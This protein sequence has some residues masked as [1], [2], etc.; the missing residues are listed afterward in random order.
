[1]EQQK[2]FIKNI[3]IK[4]FKCFKDFKAEGFGRVNL[5]GGKNNVGKTAFMEAIYLYNSYLIE[6]VYKKLLVLKTYR[7]TKKMLISN[8][9]DE[10]NL[11]AL[12]LENLDINIGIRK[13]EK[14]N[15]YEDSYILI[16]IAQDGNIIEGYRVS[17][18]LEIIKNN[19]LIE[20]QI[21]NENILVLYTGFRDDFEDIEFENFKRS[22]VDLSDLINKLNLEFDNTKYMTAKEFI[23]SSLDDN[24]LLEDIIG[25]LKLNGNYDKFNKYIDNLFDISNVDFIKKEPMVKWNNGYKK[26]SDFGDGLKS[27]I[28]IIGS[29]LTLKDEYFYIDEIENGIHYTNL[30]KLWEIILTISKEQNVQVFATTHSKE[31]IESYSRVAKRLEDKGIKFISL[32]KNSDNLIKAEIFNREEIENRI[33][34]DLDNR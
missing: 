21:K 11:K 9:S 10:E 23:S 2:H 33:K 27:V 13:E 26:L 16:D 20:Y 4:N 25:D 29:L 1:M 28:F 15:E 30:D 12:I 17:N 24:K 5:I 22:K 3:E 19:G 7:N 18:I 32:Y 8:R 14:L 31:A 6:D 34:L